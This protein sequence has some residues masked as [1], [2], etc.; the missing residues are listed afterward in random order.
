MDNTIQSIER[1]MD[2][3]NRFPNIIG[4]SKAIREIFV[5]MRQA[6]ETD[7]D[8]LITGETGTGKDLVAK[9]IHNQSSRRDNSLI[10]VSCGVVSEAILFSELFGH[11]KGAFKDAIDDKTGIFESAEGGTVILDNI[12]Q[13]PT[14][15][16]LILVN[17]LN[18]HKIQ[19]M[20]EY[21]LRDI[22]ILVIAISNRDILRE[23][24]IG[25]FRED[26]YDRLSKFHIHLPPLRERLDDI[27]LLSEHFYHQVCNQMPRISE[28]FGPGIMEML[29]QHDW[30]GNVRE[31]RNEIIQACLI[32]RHGEH[33]QKYHFS[34]QIN[35]GF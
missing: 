26:L 1:N 18:E 3:E 8:M 16:Q 4:S 13:M 9:E 6:I 21:T 5:L 29:Q 32:A 33:I 30:P 28:G 34:S 27:P 24:K 14:N 2:S 12:D 31:L 19:R 25:S 15:I 7:A 35:K 23:V 11:R 10:A 22:N 17:T 20:G